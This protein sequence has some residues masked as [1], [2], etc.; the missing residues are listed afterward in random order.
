MK[1]IV[2]ETREECTVHYRRVGVGKLH[3]E[4]D[5]AENAR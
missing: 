4:M 5:N 3:D 1:A 2:R